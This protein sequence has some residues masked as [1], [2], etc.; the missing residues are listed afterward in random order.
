MRRLSR[1]ERTVSSYPM[2]TVWPS[3][4]RPG[5]RGGVVRMT[6][7]MI[8]IRRTGTPMKKRTTPVPMITVA[9]SEV[10]S[11]EN[12]RRSPYPVV[13]RVSTTKRSKLIHEMGS[14]SRIG[15]SS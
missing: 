15:N 2:I 14:P 6:W 9:R 1:I 12:G 11:F 10:S 7:A 5:Q 4:T 13:V 3:T 8:G